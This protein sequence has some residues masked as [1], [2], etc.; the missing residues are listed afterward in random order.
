LLSIVDDVVGDIPISD[1][2]ARLDGGEYIEVGPDEYELQPGECCEVTYSHIVT[3]SD[4][5]PLKNTVTVRAWDD[6]QDPAWI[7]EQS[8]DATVDLVHP[9]IQIT[10]DCEP[11]TASVGEVIT[12]TI[13]IENT[14]TDNP[15]ITLENIVVTDPLLGAGPLSGFPSTLTQGQ[16]ATQIFTRPIED[17]DPNPL[18]NTSTVHSNPVGL[19]NDISAKDSCRVDIGKPSTK[20]DI[21]ANGEDGPIEVCEGDPVTLTICEQNDGDVALINV[22]V[23]LYYDDGTSGEI[24][25]T[26]LIGPPDTDT[27]NG[28]KILDPGEIW[29]WDYIISAVNVNTTFIAY[30][31][32]EYDGHIV[33][34]CDPLGPAPPPEVF[35]D[36]DERDPVI[37]NPIPCGGEGCTPGFWKNNAKNW[38]ASA[39][40][41][42]FSPKMRISDIFFLN[43]PLIIRGKGKSM[44]KDP[45]LLQA[46]DANGGDVNAMIRHGVAAMLNACSKCVNYPTNNPLEIIIMIEDTLNGAPEAYTVDELHSMFSGWNEASC[47]VNQHGEC[48][49]VE[50]EIMLP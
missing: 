45:T 24:K 9:K 20:I 8:D 1:A 35:C 2:C 22:S 46:L 43:K 32:G 38:E 37:V 18:E 50:E 11:Q 14:S 44:I 12:Y 15:P 23:D 5:D 16:T 4:P 29:C 3:D 41:D 34:W 19:E 17:T 10:K 40:C 27:G 48:V 6:L 30:G 31:S 13:T 25:L 21:K 33:T 42:L 39:W 26:T 36:A 28:D 47:P 7:L 49:D